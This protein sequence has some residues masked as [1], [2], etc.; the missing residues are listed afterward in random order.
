MPARRRGREWAVGTT[1][2]SEGSSQRIAGVV[3]AMAGAGAALVLLSGSA[4]AAGAATSG[5]VAGPAELAET[6]ARIERQPRYRQ[7]DWGYQVLD[8]KSG[9]VLAAQ[10]DQ[11][12]FDPGSTMK[13]Y[14]V[15]TALSKYGSNY[16]FHTPVY[17]Q[18]TVAGGALSGNL[19]LVAS[20]D[21]SLGLREQRNGTLYY[22]SLSKVN[23]NYANIGL[24]SSRRSSERV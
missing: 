18:G 3:T 12:M 16:R 19:V 8:E 13:L 1:I 24:P 6:I 23:Q 20:G 7:S 10:N 21:V 9:K 14:S 2:P 15:S 4:T 17:R 22:E 5:D 11:K